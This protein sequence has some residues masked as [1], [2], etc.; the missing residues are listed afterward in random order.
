MKSIEYSIKSNGLSFSD[1]I[2]LEDDVFLSDLEIE[3]IKQT[4]FDNWYKVITT[5]AV[6][7]VE[8]ILT[9]EIIA[10]ILIEE[11]IASDGIINGG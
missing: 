11:V 5:P 2:V 9:E 4:R 8:P 3:Q 6:E 10:P 1:A 7:N